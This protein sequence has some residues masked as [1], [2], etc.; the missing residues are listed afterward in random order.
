MNNSVNEII[1]SYRRDEIGIRT[2]TNKLRDLG[3]SQDYI[4]LTFLK[5]M[6]ETVDTL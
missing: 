2:L 5:L 4:K 6:K 1:E 3:C